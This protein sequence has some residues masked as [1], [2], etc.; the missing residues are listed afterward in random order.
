VPPPVVQR[1]TPAVRPAWPHAGTLQAELGGRALKQ[2]VA[3]IRKHLDT[4]GALTY[5]D[6]KPAPED[7]QKENYTLI[8]KGIEGVGENYKVSLEHVQQVAD[9]LSKGKQTV[10]VLD[11]TP[12]VTVVVAEIPHLDTF[13]DEEAML[14]H[15]D[16]AQST[17]R[18]RVDGGAVPE[19]KTNL[20][21]QAA[22][23]KPDE[24]SEVTTT[25]GDGEV[26]PLIDAL[27]NFVGYLSKKANQQSQHHFTVALVGPYGPCNGCKKRIAKFVE[28]WGK[29]ATKLMKHGVTAKLTVT[30]KYQNEPQ[31]VRTQYYGYKEDEAQKA[32]YRHTLI[33]DITGTNKAS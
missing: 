32:P 24:S 20:D 18:S 14:S 26:K 9:R 16:P 29:A 27:S 13:D 5:D 10:S 30:Y 25:Q 22:L 21:V 7:K 28:L 3:Y 6:A 17:L 2:I 8:S 11:P 12:P 4:P 31:A 1:Q 15:H 23:L 19:A 33:Q